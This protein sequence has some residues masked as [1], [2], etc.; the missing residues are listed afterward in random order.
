M[1]QAVSQ[2]RICFI[3]NHLIDSF[4]N[5]KTNQLVIAIAGMIIVN[6]FHNLELKLIIHRYIGGYFKNGLTRNFNI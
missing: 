2:L 6:S 5:I 4:N 3:F 1:K